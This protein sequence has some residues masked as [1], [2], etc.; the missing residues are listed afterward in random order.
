MDPQ[1][2][3]SDG[4][5]E[6]WPTSEAH[7][8]CG[9]VS[10]RG[11]R[12]QPRHHP[13]VSERADIAIGRCS[14]TR[15]RRRRL[16][17][18]VQNEKFRAAIDDGLAAS[19]SPS[20]SGASTEDVVMALLSP[21]TIACANSPRTVVIPARGWSSA[22]RGSSTGARASPRPGGW[23]HPSPTSCACSPTSM[24]T[25]RTALARVITAVIHVTMTATLHLDDTPEEVKAV[26]R[27]QLA[28]V[29]RRPHEPGAERGRLPAFPMLAEWT[30]SWD[31]ASSPSWRVR[32]SRCWRSSPSSPSATADAASDPV[33][34]GSVGGCG[35][36]LLGDLDLHAHPDARVG[37]LPLPRTEP[38]AVRVRRRESA[39]PSPS[40]GAT[41][42]IPSCCRWR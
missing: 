14:G 4:V 25:R 24:S 17:I 19:G 11:A 39:P 13:G 18:M 31:P 6:R 37:R 42:P 2:V 23:R 7:P 34:H 29:L 26:V 33:A 21:V 40:R 22:T 36:V 5:R 10:L 32:S 15:R 38:A 35:G 12:G 28:A 16:L 8:G 9:A 3:R 20:L 30:T 27:S 41:S 1:S